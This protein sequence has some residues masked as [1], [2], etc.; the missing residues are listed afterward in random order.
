M[1]AK[2]PARSIDLLLTILG[3]LVALGVA[4][5]VDS[6]ALATAV[7]LS[8]VFVLPGYAA[9]AALFPPRAIGR[10]LRLVL[11]VVLSLAALALGGL[12]LH[13]VTAL[14]RG[15]FVGLLAVVTI[16]AAAVALKGR[17]GM[18]AGRSRRRSQPRPLIGVAVALAATIGLTGVAIAIA[19][20]GA[21]R[22]IDK[23]HFSALWMVPQGGGRVPPSEPPVVV[24]IGNQEGK[25]VDYRLAVRQGGR[26]IGTWKMALDDGEE[27]EIT[28]PAEALSDTGTLVASLHRFRQT[29]RRVSIKLDTAPSP[30]ANG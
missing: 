19:S 7:S 15:T 2:G 30:R 17:Q 24:G 23:S 21:H 10:D 13:L 9:S 6:G 14:G 22:Q 25:T 12:V 11:T 26:E 3:A 29:Y 8:L 4:L 1:A 27:W 18:R 16:L 20:A 5:F 28:L